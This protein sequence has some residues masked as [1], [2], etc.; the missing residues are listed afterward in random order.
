MQA[1]AHAHNGL[2]DGCPHLNLLLRDIYYCR[3]TAAYTQRQGHSHSK[4][5][6]A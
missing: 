2:A 4:T 3:L 6:V 1:R 5:H